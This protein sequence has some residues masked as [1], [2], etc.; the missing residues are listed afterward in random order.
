V[1]QL[2][3]IVNLHGPTFHLRSHIT[4]HS[5]HAVQNFGR[6]VCPPAHEEKVQTWNHRVSPRLTKATCACISSTCKDSNRHKALRNGEHVVSFTPWRCICNNFVFSQLYPGS[7]EDMIPLRSKVLPLTRIR[8]SNWFAGLW[9]HLDQ[10]VQFSSSSSSQFRWLSQLRV[11]DQTLSLTVAHFSSS[12][13]SSHCFYK[14][15][16]DSKFH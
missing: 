14:E 5:K 16:K 6:K 13:I 8:F 2:W 7:D 15:S 4:G 3:K 11:A 12:L 10:P 1:L 9:L